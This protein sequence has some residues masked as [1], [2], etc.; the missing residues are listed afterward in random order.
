MPIIRNMNVFM[1]S[2]MTRAKKILEAEEVLG[3]SVGNFIEIDQNTYK[4]TKLPSGHGKPVFVLQDVSNEHD[5]ATFITVSLES[6]EKLLA[7]EAEPF[8]GDDDDNE[9]YSS[10]HDDYISDY[11]DGDRDFDDDLRKG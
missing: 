1:E 8:P 3:L 10:D 5:D 7:Y 2:N 9:Y 11:D 4:V 6:M